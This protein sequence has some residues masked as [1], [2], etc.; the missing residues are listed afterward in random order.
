[1]HLKFGSSDLHNRRFNQDSAYRSKA[2]RARAITIGRDGLDAT[3]EGNVINFVGRWLEHGENG[4]QS[5]EETPA[6]DADRPAIQE[7]DD[8]ASALPSN[9]V[10]EHLSNSKPEHVNVRLPPQTPDLLHGPASRPSLSLLTVPLSRFYQDL[11]EELLGHEFRDENRLR[12]PVP[13]RIFNKP[14]GKL[15]GPMALW[16]EIWEMLNRPQAGSMTR[17]ALREWVFKD[18][19]I[20]L[21]LL[22]Y[23]F[24][25]RG[26]P[27]FIQS[28]TSR[29]K[30]ILRQISLPCSGRFFERWPLNSCT[31][32]LPPQVLQVV[33]HA[34]RMDETLLRL[35]RAPKGIYK[36]CTFNDSFQHI[37]SQRIS[38]LS[39]ELSAV[40]FH[41]PN[42]DL[43]GIPLFADDQPGSD[44]GYSYVLPGSSAIGPPSSPWTRLLVAK[45][46]EM[47][48][49][50]I[51][52]RVALWS[53][54]L[55]SCGV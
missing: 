8:F 33:K 28:R 4:E 34:A 55:D 31:T 1:M 49:E 54:S 40:T 12:I 17:T 38:S 18:R 11:F 32:P 24:S 25:L 51:E 41:T 30:L 20:T 50:K 44:R 47:L 53:E 7:A 43:S 9:W 15:I 16:P 19:A 42:L 3:N 23:S 37:C 36:G 29:Y 5:V 48:R 26:P 27:S 52:L 46:I 14:K 22:M 6:G 35:L 39:H 2:L 21:A 13:Y 45:Q 10:Q